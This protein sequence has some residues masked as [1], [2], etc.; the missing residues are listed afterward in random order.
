MR[1]GGEPGTRERILAVAEATLGE[2]G[3]HGTRLHEI[4]RR[5][6]IQK[7]SLFHYF[8]SKEELYRAVLDA[9]VGETEQTIRRALEAEDVPLQKV[10]ALI[11]A[12]VHLIAAHPQRTKI[13]LRQSLGDAPSAY[14]ATDA[15]RLLQAVAGF[16]ADGQRAKVFAP[17]DPHALVLGVVGMV[18][19]FFTSAPVLAP[20]WLGDPSSAPNVERVQRYVVEIVE[21][22]LS[23]SLGAAARPTRVARIQSAIPPATQR[24]ET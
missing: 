16:I 24:P 3:Y 19:F 12:Y 8:S 14:Q 9:G 17:I 22:C 15:Q 21:H 10:R 6:G 23:P 18:A 4:A 2:C 20:A 5:V 13:F 11:T 7:A 1:H